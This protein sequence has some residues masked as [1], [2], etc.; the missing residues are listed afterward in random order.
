MEGAPVDKSGLVDYEQFTKLI[1]N[2]KQEEWVLRLELTH[3]TTL[4]KAF[5]VLHVFFILIILPLF[6]TG[7]V[8]YSHLDQRK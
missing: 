7:R 3:L 6:L 1:K 2:G 5:L 8:V 4:I